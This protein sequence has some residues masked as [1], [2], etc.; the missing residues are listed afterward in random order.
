[1]SE[2]TFKVLS[3]PEKEP[4]GGWTSEGKTRAVGT[5]TKWKEV[6]DST[7]SEAH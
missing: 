1:M 3:H 4:G 5:G 7:P 6:A 2:D